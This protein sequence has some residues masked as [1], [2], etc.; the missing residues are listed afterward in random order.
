MQSVSVCVVRDWLSGF[1][2]LLYE[3]SRLT[4]CVCA[5]AFPQIRVVNAFRSSLSPYEGLEKPESRSSI[6][7]F[8]THPEFRIED[9]EPHIP[10][11]DDT[12]AEDDAP[13]KRNATPTPPPPPSPSPNQNNNA[14][15]SGVYLLLDNSKSAT[16]SAPESPMHSVETSL[17][18]APPLP[19]L[20]T[21]SHTRPPSRQRP[22]LA[23]RTHGRGAVCDLGSRLVLDWRTRASVHRNVGCGC[24]YY[25]FFFFSNLLLL[26]SYFIL[27][28]LSEWEGLYFHLCS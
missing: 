10:L 3:A 19:F 22:A 1:A 13:T 2:P 14:M 18:S 23:Q 16:P 9:S 15:D 8:M 27:S 24:D 25:F 4:V 6:H 11:I 28:I 5:P 7:N 20:H 21:L 17:W 26:L 12:D